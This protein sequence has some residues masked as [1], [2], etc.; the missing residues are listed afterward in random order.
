MS[1]DAMRQPGPGM[2]PRREWNDITN[3]SENDDMIEPIEQNDAMEN[4][5]TNE[6]IEPIDSAEPTHPIDRIDPFDPMQRSESSDRIDDLEPFVESTAHPTRSVAGCT[7]SSRSNHGRACSCPKIS[8]ASKSNGSAS[9][10]RPDDCSTSPSSK[11]TTASQK[12]MPISRNVPAASWRPL[13][14]ASGRPSSSAKRALNRARWAWMAG[15]ASPGPASSTTERYRRT[16]V[17][18]P[19]AKAASIPTMKPLR[20]AGWLK[21]SF[22]LAEKERWAASTADAWSPS[23]SRTMPVTES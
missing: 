23:A 11:S 21:P 13:S 2:T 14:A 12:G 5:E 20:A 10:P 3:H 16:A 8:R 15:G 4:A 1:T 7:R 18:S 22:V 17:R 9:D 6:P 19:R